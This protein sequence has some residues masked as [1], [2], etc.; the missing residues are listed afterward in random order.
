MENQNLQNDQKVVEDLG[1][2][3][4][5]KQK[6]ALFAKLRSGNEKRKN[7]EIVQRRERT[8]KKQLANQMKQVRAV[9]KKKRIDGQLTEKKLVK[10]YL[11]SESVKEAAK[12]VGVTVQHASN[13][14]IESQKSGSLAE[15]LIKAGLTFERQA[16]L[17]KE[18]IDYNKEKVIRVVGEGMNA[19]EIE[20]MRDGRLALS[21][22]Q[23]AAKFTAV[24]ADVLANKVDASNIDENTALLAIKSLL[25]KLS[26]DN[27]LVVKQSID[28]LIDDNMK[29]VES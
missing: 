29:V 16:E 6:E 5:L 17:H 26:V 10:E 18:L 25:M 21:A 28:A 20:E 22:A 7:G 8:T 27:L 9:Q 12:K 23:H 15:A 11:R 19:R 13:V 3:R 4:S 2:F 14:L 24:S 1:N